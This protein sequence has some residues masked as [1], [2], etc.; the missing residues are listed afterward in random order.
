MTF[1]PILIYVGLCFL[2]ALRGTRT[3]IGFWGTLF[4]SMLITPVLMYLALILLNPPE[5]TTT[6]TT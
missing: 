3:R 2:V 1:L 4:L 6:P 5:S